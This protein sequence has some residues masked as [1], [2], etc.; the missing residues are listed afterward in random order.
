MLEIPKNIFF[1][2]IYDEVQFDAAE[3]FEDKIIITNKEE[4]KTVEKLCFVELLENNL[5]VVVDSG[6][7]Q[8]TK[9][10]TKWR[11][12]LLKGKHAQNI[13]LKIFNW[14]SFIIIFC[15]FASS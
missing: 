10:S 1:E 7:A 15:T 8:A 6:E 14:K 11:V 5:D 2:D 3:S 9:N 12:K 4:A 13:K